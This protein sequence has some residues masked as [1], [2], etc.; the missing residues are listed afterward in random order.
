MTGGGGRGCAN[1]KYFL[2]TGM[3]YIVK[4]YLIFIFFFTDTRGGVCG[5]D[6]RW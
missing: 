3:G 6:H 1:Y 5:D 2:S 4:Y